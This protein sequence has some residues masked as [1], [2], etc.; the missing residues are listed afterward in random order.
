[1][2]HVHTIADWLAAAGLLFVGLWGVKL[3]IGGAYTAAQAW[4]YVAMI[5]LGVALA[6]GRV[7][8]GRDRA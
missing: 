8:E 2:K 5:L 6:V 1:M 4:P 7:T 3:T